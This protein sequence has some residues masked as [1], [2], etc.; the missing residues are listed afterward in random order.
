MGKLYELVMKHDLFAGLDADPKAMKVVQKEIRQY[1]QERMEI[2]LGMRQEKTEAPAG[3]PMELFPFNSL[4]VEILKAIAATATKGESR[5]AEPLNLGP[6]PPATTE[7]PQSDWFG[8]KP[9]N[10]SST[11]TRP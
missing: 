7:D 11:E 8:C 6:Q 3:F 5:D 2:M 10:A 4:E 9:Y 1:A